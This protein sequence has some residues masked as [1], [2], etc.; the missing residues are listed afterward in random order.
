MDLIV[1]EVA[2]SGAGVT[3]NVLDL[4][5]V[6]PGDVLAVRD[7]SG[8][9]L[10]LLNLDLADAAAAPGG[11]GTFAGLTDDPHANTLLAAAL[12]GLSNDTL[13]QKQ[14]IDAVLL[15]LV[16]LQADP[17]TKSY[18]DG[19][20][21]TI[22]GID[23]GQATAIQQVQ[24][25]L[26]SDDGLLQG[27]L[28]TQATHTTQINQNTSDLAGL[29]DV[30]YA[31]FVAINSRVPQYVYS[32]PAALAAATRAIIFTRDVSLT[33]ATVSGLLLVG[34]N[35][36]FD[37]PTGQV[38]T[39]Q[40]G[41]SVRNLQGS[42]SPGT[43]AIAAGN[44]LPV[45]LENGLQQILYSVQA[46][47]TL[48]LR[49]NTYLDRLANAGTVILYDQSGIN[50][51]N[52]TGSGQVIDKRSGGGGTSYDDTAV[53]ASIALT[54][55]QIFGRN[56]GAWAAN[57]DYLQF[58]FVTYSGTQYYANQ[59]FTSGTAFVA[60]NWTAG[61]YA[62]SV[63]AY[64]FVGATLNNN[65]APLGFLATTSIGA[66]SVNNR[67]D[68]IG[69][70]ISLGQNCTYNVLG[71]LGT[72]SLGDGSSYNRADSGS[73][74]FVLGTSCSGNVKE[75][76]SGSFT[77]GN[78]VAGCRLLAGCGAATFGDNT[79]NCSVE[80]GSNNVVFGAGC[81]RVRV[82][83]TQG[84][85]NASF[86][87]AA[88]TTDATYVNG[89]LQTA[90]SGG[91]SGGSY[92]LP[93][94]TSRQLGGVKV[95]ATLTVLAD[96][97]LDFVPGFQLALLS[98]TTDSN[99][100]LI[101]EQHND[102]PSAAVATY[103]K[104]RGTAA[105]PAGLQS[106]DLIAI[107]VFSAY[108]AG[109]YTNDRGLFGA[110]ADDNGGIGMAMMT[111]TTDGNYRP[112]LRIGA[113]GGVHVGDFG[114]VIPFSLVRRG[115]RLAVNGR[116]HLENTSEPALPT[117]GGVVYVENGALKFKGANGTVTVLAPA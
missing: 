21:A 85:A 41:A 44:G 57:T 34:Q 82:L 77:A 98:E 19:L 114:S 81:Q 63:A 38:L 53:K 16:P 31:V 52:L 70:N 40:N 3:G 17:T 102:G 89:V 97:T 100:G 54:Q 71:A 103:K 55:A 18:V 45:T 65:I 12:A 50:A 74:N 61:S 75:V 95:G 10:P 9:Y 59:A 60:S 111:G 73:G 105:S 79:Q 8:Q 84:T 6:Q 49:G 108:Y 24:Q 117:N 96:G 78:A 43:V 104:S 39:L 66:G 106:G 36:G 94:A 67:F 28:N 93:A 92:S 69:R 26:A 115:E 46:G 62:S 90:G 83:N 99:R 32:F 51:A 76:G 88:G 91:G 48:V 35:A 101:I 87:V 25:H 23:A 72:M 113:G 27:L 30:H 112:T 56:R 29:Q 109:A 107:N 15:A 4:Y 14:R 110:Y 11:P 20:V 37:L 68:R 86:Q 64:Q 58:D 80:Q 7:A 22:S 1:R 5:E 33:T 2:G 116:L 47:A 42:A 13:T